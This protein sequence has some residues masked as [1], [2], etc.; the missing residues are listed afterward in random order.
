[1]AASPIRQH[2]R[3]Q[4]CRRGGG[5]VGG[6]AEVTWIVDVSAV[7]FSHLEAG[8][9]HR[10][11]RLPDGSVGSDPSGTRDIGPGPPGNGIVDPPTAADR[12]PEIVSTWSRSSDHDLGR[13]RAVVPRPKVL[14]TPYRGS[15][16]SNL[17]NL[18]SR[19]H[20]RRGSKWRRSSI[21]S[22][23]NTYGTLVPSGGKGFL[24]RWRPARYRR[25][26]TIPG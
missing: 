10:V 3:R 1:M 15:K 7:D 6:A 2:H 13:S 11:V 26:Q 9:R 25:R 19:T 24:P 21:V 17:P 12:P 4:S 23:D 16:P 22:V 20:P 18:G 14:W 5:R 8:G